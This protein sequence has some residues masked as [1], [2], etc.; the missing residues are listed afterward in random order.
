M[1]T[2]LSIY[3]GVVV[4]STITV[5]CI[6]SAHNDKESEIY[7]KCKA[8]GVYVFSDSRILKCEVK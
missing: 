5:L 7:D 8:K 3:L 2:Y 6:S 1:K 4:F